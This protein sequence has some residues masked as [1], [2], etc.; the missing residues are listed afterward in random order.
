MTVKDEGNEQGKEK[1]VEKKKNGKRTY[2]EE[3][4]R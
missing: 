1:V 2:S 3:G 4:R